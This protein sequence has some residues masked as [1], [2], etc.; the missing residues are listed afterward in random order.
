MYSDICILFL[1]PLAVVAQWLHGLKVQGGGRVQL[2]KYVGSAGFHFVSKITYCGSLMAQSVSVLIFGSRL[3]CLT[4]TG[5]MPRLDKIIIN[6]VGF[7]SMSP[8]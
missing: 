3:K 4:D 2:C 7:Y 5:A 8:C 6:V 1:L